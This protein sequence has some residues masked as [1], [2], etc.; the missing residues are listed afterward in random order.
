MPKLG[1][2]YRGKGESTE[3]FTSIYD[4]TTW[5]GDTSISSQRGGITP[6]TK[7]APAACLYNNRI[8]MVYNGHLGSNI[9][10][11]FFDGV[12]WGSDQKISD[13]S[14]EV[15]PKTDQA[16]TLVVYN[17]LLYMFYV[18]AGSTTI[19]GSWFDGWQWHGDIP[20]GTKSG[21][22]VKSDQPP[23][24]VVFN[25]KLYLIYKGAGVVKLYAA[26]FD[27]GDWDGDK[28]I[29]ELPGGIDPWSDRG[30]AAA[31]FND[32]LVLIYKG[33]QK[34]GL[35]IS[36]LDGS[37]W[38]GD[39]KL[40]DQ[41]G[42]LDA[43][44]DN[45][46]NLLVFDNKLWLAYR[47][48]GN[49][50]IFISWFDGSSWSGDVSIA[51][52]SG[53]INPESSFGPGL[54]LMPFPDP[55]VTTGYRVQQTMDMHTKPMPAPAGGGAV[56]GGMVAKVGPGA[57]AAVPARSGGDQP[58]PI[59]DPLICDI[60]LMGTHDSAAINTWLPTTAYACHN[61][62]ITQQL[63]AGVRVL[64]VR[65]KVQK[66]DSTFTFVTC[67]GPHSGGTPINEYQSFVSLLDECRAFL[68]SRT[69]EFL[70]MSLKI[71]DWNSVD[72]GRYGAAVYDALRAVLQAYPVIVNK[73]D[74]PHLSEAMGKIYLI[75]RINEDLSLGV[76]MNFGD[77]RDGFW[78]EPTDKRQFR[79]YI[80][81][82][83][84][85]LP[86]IDPWST[87]FQL[88]IDAVKQP[89]Q[90]GEMLINFGSSTY[91]GVGKLN[92]Q[93]RLLEYLG[94]LANRPTSFG[95]SLF[96]YINVTYPTNAYP[97]LTVT[98]MVNAATSNYRDFPSAYFMRGN[99]RDC[100]DG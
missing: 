77:N 39:Q 46:P 86:L 52:R 4:G 18:G 88:F 89:R 72:P 73:S 44:T 71:D 7:S 2:F 20:I 45:A 93:G 31:V 58:S 29:S 50:A 37:T 42:H 96:D 12:T 15:D 3:I 59:L 60:S 32:R 1:L 90:R 34:D 78:L 68:S 30:P 67:H 65:L 54:S 22:T 84:K 94:V 61:M 70:V 16:P 5:A 91:L 87:K 9:F 82:R 81:D 6:K 19:Y 69:W 66:S 79:V 48:R 83:Y 13:L 98:Q 8:L 25:N 85:G 49:P 27:G 47:G 10:M 24:A 35:F 75:N 23:T 17:D 14:R 51:S 21:S 40:S 63:E 57:V 76:P 64:D 95:W 28:P 74:I 38:S 55:V 53:M 41:A 100:Y 56:K 97:A 43:R 92:I 26:W 33:A 11:S 36:W 80:Q 62:S 99:G